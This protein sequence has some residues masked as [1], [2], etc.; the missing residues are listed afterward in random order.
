MFL[1]VFYWANIYNMP[2][3]APR[4]YHMVIV[5]M[6]SDIILICLF[7]FVIFQ[8]VLIYAGKKIFFHL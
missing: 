2:F 5:K 8:F 1:K 6:L 7:S 4:T 3:N